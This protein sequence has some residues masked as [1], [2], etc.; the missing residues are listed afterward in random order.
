MNE[1]RPEI[2]GPVKT[3]EEITKILLEIS[4]RYPDRRILFRGQSRLHESIRSGRARPNVKVQK[5][6][7]AG[8][9][10]LA[11]RMLNLSGD[12]NSYGY[13]RAI[14][15]HYG[16]ATHFVDLTEDI[17]VAAWFATRKYSSKIMLYGGSTMRQ[18]EHVLYEPSVEE[19]GCILVLAVAEAEKL[20]ESGRLFDL[21]TLPVECAR[22]HRQ[23]GWLM[24]DRPPTEPTPNSF[25]VA[26][27]KVDAKAWTTRF[28]TTDLFPSP[29]DDPAFGV[30]LSLPFVQVPAAY[31]SSNE[32]PEKPKSSDELRR[33]MESFCF[34]QR[35]LSI[36][37]YGNEIHDESIDH[38]WGD[39]TIYEPHHMR[40][41]KWW[42]FDLESAHRGV[43]GDIKDTVKITLSPEAKEILFSVEGRKCS[44][45]SLGSDGIFFT[46]AALDHD[47]VIDHA[48]PY[49]GVWLQRDDELIVETP[50][51]ADQDAL[52][53]MAGHSYF[54]QDGILKRQLMA[55]ACKCGKP[56]THDKRIRSVLQLSSLL[57]DGTLILL[58]HPLMADLG[59]HVVIAGSEGRSMLPRVSSFKK[60]V[61]ALNSQRG[62]IPNPPPADK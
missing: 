3:L 55:S 28:K 33:E 11:M 51:E 9:R 2:F 4:N 47:K 49:Y 58:P 59:W 32:D 61:R 20:C 41:W 35:A 6:V 44:W 8:W 62:S 22:P 60:V 42:R 1:S 57:E 25:W 34:S 38:K 26:T 30:L 21:S 43:K 5:D 29:A 52:N 54:L 48:P 56:E 12:R 19:D 50:M 24:L 31:F 10:S 45:P 40:M 13:A 16:M 36:P 27:I 39:F 23:K 14:L 17:E 15:Q 46:F 7:E 37:E 18:Y 53:V